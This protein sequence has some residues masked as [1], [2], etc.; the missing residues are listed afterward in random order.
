MKAVGELMR[1]V[2]FMTIAYFTFIF[3]LMNI[4]IDLPVQRLHA[5][6]VGMPT[7]TKDARSMGPGVTMTGSRRTGRVAF[8]V[9]PAV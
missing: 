8:A 5:A 6:L 7:D 4:R 9:H 2:F 1:T 3:L